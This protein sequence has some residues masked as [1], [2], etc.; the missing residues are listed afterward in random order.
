MEDLYKKATRIKL[1]FISTYGQ[2][3]VEDLWDLPMKSDKSESLDSIYIELNKKISEG[4]SKS[5]FGNTLDSTLK[6]KLDIIKDVL[7]TRVAKIEAKKETVAKLQHN[8]NIDALI[9]AKTIEAQKELTIEEL[10]KLKK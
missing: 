8:A 9:Q 6:L 10:E 3:H 5:F 7:E 1:R 4:T 2:L